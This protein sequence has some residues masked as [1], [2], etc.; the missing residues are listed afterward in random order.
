LL[1]F[2]NFTIS[3][4]ASGGDDDY[5]ASRGVRFVYTPELRDNGYGFLLPPEQIYPSGTETW[6]AWEVILNFLLDEMN[7]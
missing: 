6:A 3:D 7:A 1:I 4:P 5:F 2:F